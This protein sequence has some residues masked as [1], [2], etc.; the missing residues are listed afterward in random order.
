[1]LMNSFATTDAS[2]AALDAHP[3]LAQD[4]PRE[5]IQNKVPKL[6]ARTLEPIDWP[7]DPA[8]EWAPPGHGDLYVALVTSGMLATLL[9]HGYR[10]AFV[11]NAD[12]LGAT[13]DTRILRWFVDSGAPFAMEVADRTA[14]DRKGGHLARRASDGHLVLREIAQT[15]EADV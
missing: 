1:V 5:F 14:A 8:L 9:E 11:S 2:L 10:Y 4:V 15:P 7:A 3:E 13:L 6:D 12:N